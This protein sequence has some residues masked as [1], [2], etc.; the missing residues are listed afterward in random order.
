LVVADPLTRTVPVPMRLGTPPPGFTLS[1]VS[2]V[3]MLLAV[4]V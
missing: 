2:E 1:T 3:A 4:S